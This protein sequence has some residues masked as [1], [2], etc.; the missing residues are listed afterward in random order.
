MIYFL[1]ILDNNEFEETGPVCFPSQLY[2]KNLITCICTKDGR[3]PHKSCHDTFQS[4]PPSNVI[5]YKCTP[6]TYIPIDCNV[7]RCGPGGEILNDRCTR[8]I[9]ED[10]VHRRNEIAT[11]TIFSKCEEKYWYSLAPCQF[12]FC[13]NEN[14]LV[15]NTGNYYTKILDL[16]SYKLNV[17]G[18]DLI[19]EAI[20]LIPDNLRTLRTGLDLNK[21]TTTKPVVKKAFL[22]FKTNYKGVESVEENN[23]KHFK[24]LNIKLGNN[25]SNDEYYS[26]E[27][28]ESEAVPPKQK[29]NHPTTK[30][31]TI[32]RGTM[33]LPITQIPNQDDN[34]I[35]DVTEVETIEENLDD[36]TKDLD[37]EI[38][39]DDDDES[40]GI[41]VEFSLEKTLRAHSDEKKTG[42]DNR[43]GRY[44]S[45]TLKI[46]KVLNKVFQMALRKSMVSLSER[47][48]CI[49]GATTVHGCNMCFCLRNKKL[50][51]TNHKC[52][53]GKKA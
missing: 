26:D 31:T 6:D 12:C 13:V 42:Q 34:D 25:N 49:P 7:C 20:E 33:E 36:K 27:T 39:E 51:C 30:A 37:V 15:C 47:T 38:K 43:T 16:G 1:L 8:N 22:D 46:P 2:V 24:I 19:K 10:D 21:T 3:W 32:D 52:N 29:K 45:S 35:I 18:K 44:D 41:E 23:N 28:E 14:K 5:T 53:G 11:N 40:K 50:L 9:C 4:L 17:C 48:K